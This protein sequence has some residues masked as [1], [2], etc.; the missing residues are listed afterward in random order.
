MQAVHWLAV[1][2]GGVDHHESPAVEA[3]AELLLALAARFG[4]ARHGGAG[5]FATEAAD[6]AAAAADKG[7]T[8]EAAH[9]ASD[10]VQAVLCHW[11]YAAS[12]AS[13]G[14]AAAADEAAP[15]EAASARW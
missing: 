3:A 14:T 1:Q 8:A 10:A 4:W 2:S 15:A 5:H 12:A 7:T 11:L 9:R 6:G 13:D